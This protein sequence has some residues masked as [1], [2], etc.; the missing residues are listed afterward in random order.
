MRYKIRLMIVELAIPTSFVQGVHSTIVLICAI[1]N[2][3]WAIARDPDDLK[4]A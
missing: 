4:E 2:E 3:L 1:C